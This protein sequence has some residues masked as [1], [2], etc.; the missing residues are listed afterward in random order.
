M[1]PPRPRPKPRRGG[2]F[3]L[4]SSE[5]WNPNRVPNCLFRLQPFPTVDCL[6]VWN[7]IICQTPAADH[8]FLMGTFIIMLQ[9]AWRIFTITGVKMIKMCGFW[10]VCVVCVHAC[11][12]VCVCVCVCVCKFSSPPSARDSI[13]GHTLCWRN[14]LGGV[15]IINKTTSRESQGTQLGKGEPLW[16]TQFSSQGS[17]ALCLWKSAEDGL[18]SRAAP[19]LIMYQEARKGV[20]L[21]FQFRER[22][23]YVV[24]RV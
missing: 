14:R 12:R 5:R 4:P 1:K 3:G 21:S 9:C 13:T 15:V 24:S 10:C 23:K 2:P 20:G 11:I 6:P 19:C 7:E 17:W 8:S 22:K 16:S 18:A